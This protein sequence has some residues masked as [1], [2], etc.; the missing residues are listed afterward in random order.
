MS[1]FIFDG[2]AYRQGSRHQNE[3]GR[4]M[5]DSVDWRGDERVLDL[6]CGDGALTAMIAERVPQGA[7]VGLDASGSMLDTARK[8]HAPN[9]SWQH[10]AMES[11]D[12]EP[13]YDLVVSNAAMHWVLDHDALLR[14]VYGVLKPGG[15]LR[16]NFMAEGNCATFM[17]TVG[18][19]MRADEFAFCF[20]GFVWPWYQ[21]SA[22][23]YTRQITTAGFESASVVGQNRDRTFADADEMIRWI[24]QPAL[25]PFL[26]RLLETLRPRFR[27]RVIETMT[28]RCG[29]ADGGFF[30]SFRRIDVTAKRGGDA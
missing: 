4:A 16:V 24:D 10:G 12:A 7:V 6:G 15:R 18:E 11:I 23:V 27:Q 22:D 9:L 5:V 26:P 8:R 28:K 14:L 25:L 20:D 3:W 1:Q 19:L 17:K 21:P 30:E 2:E 13:G 29:R